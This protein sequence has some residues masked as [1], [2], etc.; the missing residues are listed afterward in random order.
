MIPAFEVE[1]VKEAKVQGVT[2][3]T[4]W[5][6]RVLLEELREVMTDIQR[7]VLKTA[8]S[9]RHRPDEGWLF[10]S[11]PSG[12]LTAVLANHWLDD[13]AA[14]DDQAP[15]LSLLGG[16]FELVLQSCRSGHRVPEPAMFSSALQHL[17]VTSHMQV[18]QA[19][20][21]DA[22]EQGVKAAEG[23]G[24]KAILVENLY[25]LNKLANFTG[26][27]VWTKTVYPIL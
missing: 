19:L 15:L 4:D 17:G 24:M 12:L 10:A 11:I 23:A 14:G 26:V 13:S 9:L 27:Q 20:W 1:C 5:S 16:H 6:V 25:V 18:Q 21:L 8:A 22:D 7:A 2:L 3:P